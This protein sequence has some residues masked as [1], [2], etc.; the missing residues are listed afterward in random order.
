MEVAIRIDRRELRVAA[1][2]EPGPFVTGDAERLRAVAR[3]AI[4]APPLG[5]GGMHEQVVRLVEVCRLDR[6]LMTL[7]AFGLVMARAAG[8]IGPTSLLRVIARETERVVV[9]KTCA[10]RDQ[11]PVRE[12]GLDEAA[13]PREMARGATA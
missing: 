8:G 10:L 6:A 1:R 11:I 4:G 13:E 3:R 9:A 7:D 5:L 12:V 2:A